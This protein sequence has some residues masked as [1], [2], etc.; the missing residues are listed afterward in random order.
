MAVGWAIEKWRDE[1]LVTDALMMAVVRQRPHPGLLHHSDRGSQYTSQGYLALL[2][3]SVFTSEHSTKAGQGQ[4][5]ATVP[6]AE[7]RVLR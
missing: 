2:I 1:Q 5:P 3:C 6:V 7:H 4:I